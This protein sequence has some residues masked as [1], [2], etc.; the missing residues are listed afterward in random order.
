VSSSQF[1]NTY[2]AGPNGPTCSSDEKKAFI[3]ND[4]HDDAFTWTLD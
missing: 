1:Y 4:I 2:G 3:R